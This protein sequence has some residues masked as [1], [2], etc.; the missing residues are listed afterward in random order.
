MKN[1]I[2]NA[3]YENVYYY[4]HQLKAA[5]SKRCR[6]YERN[7]SWTFLLNPTWLC[8]ASV[9]KSFDSIFSTSFVLNNPKLAAK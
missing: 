7:V 9:S 6:T 2:Q 8:I 5:H 1:V 4:L 3:I